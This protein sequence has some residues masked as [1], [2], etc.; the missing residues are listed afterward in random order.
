MG[1][2]TAQS[3]WRD[4]VAAV[5]EQA[6]RSNWGG[7]HCVGFCDACAD[8]SLVAMHAVPHP[9]KRLDELLPAAVEEAIGILRDALNRARA[10]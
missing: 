1:S 9:D 5:V 3:V 2:V 7:K 4:R 8:A 6:H 10:A